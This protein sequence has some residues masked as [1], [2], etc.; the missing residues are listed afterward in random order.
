M[1]IPLP[2]WLDP[3]DTQAR[4]RFY[5]MI[6][7]IYASPSGSMSVLSFRIGYTNRKSL[8]VLLCNDRPITLEKC[9]AIASCVPPEVFTVEDMRSDLNVLAGANDEL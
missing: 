9:R 1:P 3:T 7:A 8:P 5:T 2:D 4:V 6:A